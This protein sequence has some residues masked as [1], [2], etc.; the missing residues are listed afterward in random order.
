[1]MAFS[2]LILILMVV[3]LLL[4][5]VGNSMVRGALACRYCRQ[6]GIGCPALRL[7]EKRKMENTD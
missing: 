4:T 2:W 7:F 1:M 5:T 3:I 6:R